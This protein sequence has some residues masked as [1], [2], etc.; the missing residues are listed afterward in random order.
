VVAA[1]Q[2]AFMGPGD[3]RRDDDLQGWRAQLTLSGDT[4]GHALRACFS[5]HGRAEP[6]IRTIFIY[7]LISGLIVI[8]GIIG[9]LVISGEE[10]HSSVWVGYLIMLA[11]L[12]SI[13]LAVKSYRDK[14]LGGV[15]R[16]WPA[17][18]MGLAISLIAGIAYVVVW[19]A[20]LAST[21]Y[22]F[23]DDYIAATL[24]QKAAAGVTGEAYEKLVAQMQTMSESYKNPLFRFAMTFVEIFP[25]GV[26]V[27][28]VT[29]ALVRNPK[30]LPAK[31]K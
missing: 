21:G 17:F 27:S 14:T 19:E 18:G 1:L 30:F 11:G 29:A 24:K 10:P 31:A 15:I 2:I 9:S 3:K 13:L 12:S 26:L 7:G 28:L 25:V 6:M 20:Y 23:M 16:F 8:A 22:T 5:I 4:Q